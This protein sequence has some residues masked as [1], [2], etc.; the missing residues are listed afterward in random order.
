[1]CSLAGFKKE[2]LDGYAA[3]ERKHFKQTKS[4]ED[5]RYEDKLRQAIRF[6]S[7]MAAFGQVTGFR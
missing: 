5:P 4:N 1:M 3:L 6:D 7:D 2:T